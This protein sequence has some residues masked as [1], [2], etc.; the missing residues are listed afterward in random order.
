MAGASEG[1][2]ARA[3]TIFNIRNMLMGA[4]ATLSL[5]G[6]VISGYV[7]QRANTERAIS[8]EAAAVN[9]TADLLL[10]AAG[11]WARERGATNLS[12]NAP[13]PA[14]D[15]QTIAIAGFRKAADG[16]FADGLARLKDMPMA[17][18]DKLLAAA[19]QTFD[20]LVALRRQVDVELTRT[21]DARNN[22][23]VT[24]LAPTVTAMI[25]ASQNLRVAAAMDEDDVQS[26]LASLQSLKH[27]VW[28]MSEYMGRERA[29]VA[30]KIAANRPMTPQEVSTFG[31]LRGR[32]ETA[33][34]FVQAYAARRSAAP[35]VVAATQ[36]VNDDV[37][38]R[39][40]E[41]RKAVYAAGLSGQAYPL[42]SADWFATSTA[43]IDRV[44]ELSVTASN[45]AHDLALQ[46][47]H[48]S[49]V[50]LLINAL[51]MTLSLTLACV[52]LW[53]VRG[54]VIGSLRRM[55]AAMAKLADGELAIA[56]PC[57]ERRDEMGEMAQALVVFKDTAVRVRNMQ[58]ER[59]QL[60]ANAR[61]EKLRT[62]NRLA[63]DLERIIAGVMQN[64]QGA[65]EQLG[66]SAQTMSNAASDTTT[67]AGMVA[68]ATVEASTN[69]ESV[70][71]A[72]EELSKSINEI[73]RQVTDSTRIVGDAVAEAN[74]TNAMVE[75]LAEAADR[76]GEVLKLIG[77]I[78][79]QTNLLALNAT[80]EAARAGEAGRGFAVV[81]A[82]VKS[83]AEQTAR[84][85]ED[86]AAQITAIQTAAGQSV[87]AIRGIASTIDKVNGIA[88]A[89]ASAVEEQGS[90]TQEIARNVQQVA[91]GAGEISS[92]IAG[93]SDSAA[94]TGAVASS[95]LSAAENLSGQSV[96]LRDKVLALVGDIRAA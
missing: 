90:A 77:E 79:S 65:T 75:G 21:G 95:V 28:V 32:V 16:A 29:L 66:T 87:K 63:D 96:T 30:A 93:V 73:S 4:V 76:I 37:F 80:I 64:L 15:Q 31:V 57:E 25:I 5:F 14:T 60:E 17:E 43:A 48:D 26:R 13:A 89:I 39:F 19:Q 62:M 9:E 22:A 38:R 81:A 10:Q 12:L 3:R 83:L 44:I 72:A 49:F 68:S 51:L 47:T 82:E 11:N 34:E 56:I 24:Q 18:R 36:R 71:A 74:S 50:M 91:A 69:I 54:R 42:S 20:K 23:V 41:T 88:N 55:T 86:I 58:A 53:I 59:E 46:S 33:W 7:L 84:A 1:A 70:A 92:H 52:T 45:E 85:T 67:Q 35:A 78:A 27:F 40:E 94:R 61:T 8:A 6:M 2:S